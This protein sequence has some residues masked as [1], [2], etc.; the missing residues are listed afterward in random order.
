MDIKLPS[1]SGCEGLWDLHRRFLQVSLGKTVT[2][3]VV[4]SE[5]SS[6]EEIERVCGIITS[7]DPA[8]PLFLQ[9]LTLAGGEVGITAVHLLHLQETAASRLPDV[10]VIPQMHKLLGVM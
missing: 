8:V 4:V 10:R 6:V 2:V 5:R 9:P 3:K 1:T 7:L